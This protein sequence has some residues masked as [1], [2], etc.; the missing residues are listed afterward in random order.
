ML[1]AISVALFVLLS[2]IFAD[3]LLGPPLWNAE[4][5]ISSPLVTYLLIVVILAAGWAQARRIP[6]EGIALRVAA[7][8]QTPGRS[9][10]RSAGGC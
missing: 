10:I 8:A 2:W 1:T 3:G 9:R 4:D 7:G 6:E 5:G